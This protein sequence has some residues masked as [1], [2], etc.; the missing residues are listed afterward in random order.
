[1]NPVGTLVMN[2]TGTNPSEYIGG[3]WVS[4]GQGRVPI[5]LGTVEANTTTSFGDVTAGELDWITVEAKGGE[6]KHT[7]T[8]N[9]MPSHTHTTNNCPGYS[10]GTAW[11]GA[12][13]TAEATARTTT[14]TGGGGNHNNIMPYQTCYFWKRTA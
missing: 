1:M 12:S 8:V 5:G 13:G 9:E 3:T 4:W 10:S 11:V 2:I 6:Y 14:S 7:L